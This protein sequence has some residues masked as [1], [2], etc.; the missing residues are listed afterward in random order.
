MRQ[1]VESSVDVSD[2]ARFF[3]HGA[4]P[5]TGLLPTGLD[6]SSAPA[7]PPRPALPPGCS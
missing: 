2:L 7:R 1:A 3:V 5:M 6:S 4:A